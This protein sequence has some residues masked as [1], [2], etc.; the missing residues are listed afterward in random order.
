M[1]RSAPKAAIVAAAAVC[2]TFFASPGAAATATHPGADA[3]AALSGTWARAEEVPGTAA[4]NQG[5]AAH[6]AAVSCASPGDCGAGGDY[7]DGS[8]SAQA[9]VVDETNGTWGTAQEVPGTA[10]LNQ[11]AAQVN[12]VACGSA[13][14]CGAGGQYTDGS[15]H[16]Q[17]FVV[18]ETNG[19]WGTAQEVP[20]TAAS[21]GFNAITSVSC[22]SA[23][24]CGA[25]G[26]YGGPG[27]A[28]VVDE[29]NG[30]WGTAEAVPGLAALTS[31]GQITS[32]SCASADNCSAGGYYAGSSGHAFVVDETNGT[33]GTVEKV[34]GSAVN[35]GRSAEIESLSCGSAG[36]CS[37]V[38]DYGDAGRVQVFAVDETNG[39]W[40]KAEE[41]PG[42]ASQAARLASVSCASAGN[43]SA[44]GYYYRPVLKAFVVTETSGVWGKAE[45]VPGTR[46]DAGITSVSCA[47]A[48]N[49]SAGGFA[50]LGS[51]G[52]YEAIVA[53]EING[54]WGRAE[55]L[56]G[57][58]TLNHGHSQVQ[59]VSCASA[60]NCSAGG[61]YQGRGKTGE[62]FV[63]EES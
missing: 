62:V 23:G 33:W 22:A 3:H 50:L 47:S 41:V 43:C 35:K 48:G 57:I 46:T 55:E 59:S 26:D 19:T 45:K 32:V 40:G 63:A 42:T 6:L 14:N 28:F 1:R 53:S 36:N 7:T 52:R 29:T 17:A 49:C 51:R 39:I 2:A 38:G 27:G 10:A 54:T 8:G 13:G 20:G 24:A 31:S 56:P 18:D 30:T 11:G 21:P 61:D 12:S 16:I 37:A 60:G 9:F 15:G 4:L 44:G 34:A 58:G 5:N 25:G